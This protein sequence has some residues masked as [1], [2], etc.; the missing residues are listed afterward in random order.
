MDTLLVMPKDKEEFR[1]L[2]EMFEKM[3]IKS[4]ALNVDNEEDLEFASLIAD[5][6]NGDLVDEADIMSLLT[7][8]G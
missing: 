1:F 2:N 3:N 4:K 5:R 6:D 7:K 8:V